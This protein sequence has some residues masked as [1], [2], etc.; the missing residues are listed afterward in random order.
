LTQNLLF[1]DLKM[2]DVFFIKDGPIFT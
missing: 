1:V 2:K